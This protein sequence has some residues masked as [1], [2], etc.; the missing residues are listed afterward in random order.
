MK[1]KETFFLVCIFHF[2]FSSIVVSQSEHFDDLIKNDIERLRP[3]NSKELIYKFNL[4]KAVNNSSATNGS[5]FNNKDNTQIDSV[6]IVKLHSGLDDEI[7]KYYYTYDS[8]GNVAIE[9]KTNYWQ[10]INTY[11]SV[12]NKI[13][14]IWEIWENY[15]W[16]NFGLSTKEYD[17]V[18]NETLG[19]F[20]L[21]NNSNWENSTQ[22]K[23]YYN[24][25]G[26]LSSYISEDWEGNKW[27]N[28]FRVTHTYDSNFVLKSTLNQNWGDGDWTGTTWRVTYTYDSSGNKTIHLSE[29]FYNDEWINS[30]R[31]KYEYDKKENNILVLLDYWVDND[32][33]PQ[34]KWTYAYNNSNKVIWSLEETYDSVKWTN[35][36]QTFSNYNSEGN[37][38]FAKSERWLEY[39]STWV[40]G[41]DGVFIYDVDG[42]RRSYFGTEIEVFYAKTTNVKN[43]ESLLSGY[44]LSQNYPNPFNPTTVIKYKLGERGYV[45]LSV[46]N[47]LGQEVAVLV[48]KEQKAGSYKIDFNAK[49]L[50]SGVY[51]YRLTVGAFNESK[52]MILIR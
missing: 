9:T 16:V 23:F 30:L 12:G 40:P 34:K 15:Q 36:Y 3:S 41:N 22:T 50:S 39:D 48:N 51:I 25:N 37:F 42:N 44:S 5:P 49:G 38:S 17:S 20:Q 14:R 11:D 47:I 45:K 13:N 33:I 28:S 52:K 10:S 21:W 19:L 32:W 26:D 18:G 43:K 35:S 6:E 7:I 27:I 46:I 24:S 8:L 29:D 2:L 31:W 1:L 4:E